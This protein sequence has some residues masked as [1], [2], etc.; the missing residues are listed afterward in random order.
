MIKMSRT[1][2]IFLLSICLQLI[3]SCKN[4]VETKSNFDTISLNDSVSNF[5]PSQEYR[6]K[7]SNWIKTKY[8]LWKSK[9]GDLAI[10]TIDESKLGVFI[11]RYITELC[12]EG[13]P[14]SAVIDT[15]TFRYLGSSFY[16]DRKN[17]YT[18]Y[19]TSDGGNFW[20]VEGV[21]VATF[22]I[23]GSCY[24]KDKDYIYGERAMKMDN[25]DYNTFKTCEECGCYAKDKNGY[26]FWDDKIE[27][28]DINNKEILKLIE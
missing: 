23:I 17:V 28:E 20:I 22:V 7:N 19:T 15:A 21:D 24:A 4:N 6:N 10:K 9:D 8:D 16:K 18:H 27:I 11:D 25:V 5:K 12:C 26:Y 2:V 1:L 3:I 13:K 14:I